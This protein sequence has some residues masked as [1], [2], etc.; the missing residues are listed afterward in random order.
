[1]NLS[2]SRDRIV[3]GFM[4]IVLADREKKGRVNTC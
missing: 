1:M 4:N 2:F 3:P